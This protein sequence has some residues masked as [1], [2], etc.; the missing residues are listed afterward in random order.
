MMR[1]LVLGLF[2]S[3][4][5]SP[6]LAAWDD[7][8]YVEKAFE[9]IALNNEYDDD[10]HPIRKWRQPIKVWIDHRVGDQE[11]HTMLVR[12]HLTHLS[13]VTGHDVQ[14]V[15]NLEKANLRMVFTRQSRW[16]DE[17]RELWGANES[18]PFRGAICM[19]HFSVT[20]SNE[21]RR[22]L[23]VIPVDLAR[24]RG[25]LFACVVE[26][27]TQAM[28]LPNDSNEVFPS[29]FND[30]TKNSVLTPLDVTL[31]RLLYAPDIHAGMTGNKALPIVSQWLKARPA[32]AEESKKL[33]RQSEFVTELGLF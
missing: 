3:L 13:K 20:K 4:F 27:L 10:T 7:D 12:M 2:L 30:N 6:V 18:Y 22:G 24:E 31:L 23:I 28:G 8:A 32:W 21:I 14:L 5:T 17:T 15:D 33:A 11:L 25:K 26:E 19:A 9:L 16:Q 1:H 29:I